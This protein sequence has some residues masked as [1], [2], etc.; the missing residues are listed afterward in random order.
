MVEQNLQVSRTISDDL[1]TRALILGLEQITQYG[2]L[3]REAINTFK[4]KHFED[5]SQVCEF[6]LN[7]FSALYSPLYPS[8]VMYFTH[9]MIAIVNNCLHA[10]ELAQQM[11]SRNGNRND[12][13]SAYSKIVQ[14]FENLA[15]TYEVSLYCLFSDNSF[16][17]IV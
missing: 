10:M 2:L 14:N 13:S 17:L 1:M 3:Y 7:I 15:R 9:Y 12:Q 8:K 5:R 11:R 6:K 4:N 16:L